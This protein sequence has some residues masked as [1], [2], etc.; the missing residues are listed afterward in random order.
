MQLLQSL[1]HHLIETKI[2]KMKK[3]ILAS[4]TVFVISF[5]GNNAFAQYG[6]DR[7]HHYGNRNKQD[8]YYGRG[9]YNNRGYNSQ[10]RRTNVPWATPHHYNYNSHVYF[11]D[12]QVFYDPYQGGYE[13]MNG[14]RWAFS[15]N[16]PAFLANVD[17][18]GARIQVMSGVP[19]S[20]HPRTY[21]NTYYRRYPPRMHR[22]WH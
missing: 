2:I 21:Y 20:T 18:G 15:E 9:E 12:Y 22:H 11:P 4:I 13:Y 3:I 14:N 16:L 1:Y 5:I 17:L 6:H 8:H 19:L 10:V 7:G